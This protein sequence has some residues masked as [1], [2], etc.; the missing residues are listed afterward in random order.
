MNEDRG[1]GFWKVRTARLQNKGDL[2]INTAIILVLAIVVLLALVAFFLGVINP[3]RDALTD[4]A[5]KE[6]F[7]NKYLSSRCT[8]QPTEEEKGALKRTT[9]SELAEEACGCPE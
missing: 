9:G 5:I 3:S 6:S 1:P 8:L 4:Q 7:C 2:P